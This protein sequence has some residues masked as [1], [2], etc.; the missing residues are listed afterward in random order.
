MILKKNLC[1]ISWDYGPKIY[2]IHFLPP[3]PSKDSTKS[4]DSVSAV[5]YRSLLTFDE[6]QGSKKRSKILKSFYNLSNITFEVFGK[7][8]L[9]YKEWRILRKK[10]FLVDY[11]P[12]ECKGRIFFVAESSWLAH[13]LVFQVE[14][15]EW[16]GT[17]TFVKGS[18]LS[19]RVVGTAKNEF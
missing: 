18:R 6:N 1:Y 11:K 7:R 12:Q 16:H 13:S 9:Q 10:E 8:W 5:C 17:M 14:W 2:E 15:V 3:I 19:Q 4:A